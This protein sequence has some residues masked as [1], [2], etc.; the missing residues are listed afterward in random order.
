MN[1]SACC[2][3]QLFSV[4]NNS[5]VREVLSQSNSDV[6]LVDESILPVLVCRRQGPDA[7]SRG[8]FC[9][10]LAPVT[11][12]QD[13]PVRGYMNIVSHGYNLTPSDAISFRENSQ[14]YRPLHHTA[15]ARF[16]LETWGSSSFILLFIS[17]L[18][19]A[20]VPEANMNHYHFLSPCGYLCRGDVTSW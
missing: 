6:T 14:A 18:I 7:W 15:T 16:L 4:M 13:L 8:T 1:F 9:G 11:S 5:D 20:L 2:S 12:R 3:A 10:P 19:V 17:L